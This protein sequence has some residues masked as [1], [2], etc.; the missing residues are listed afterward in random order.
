M[1]DFF[2]GVNKTVKGVKVN[3]LSHLFGL[4]SE[5]NNKV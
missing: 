3:N 1:L 5:C 4:L 2:Y